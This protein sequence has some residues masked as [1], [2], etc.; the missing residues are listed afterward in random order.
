M[1]KAILKTMY[2]V[3]ILSSCLFETSALA[4][5]RDPEVYQIDAYAVNEKMAGAKGQVSISLYIVHNNAQVLINLKNRILTSDNV[6]KIEYLT[7]K[8]DYPLSKFEKTEDKVFFTI[9]S[10]VYEHILYVKHSLIGLGMGSKNTL[11]KDWESAPYFKKKKIS[12]LEGIINLSDG[13]FNGKCGKLT[14]KGKGAKEFPELTH[15]QKQEILYLQKYID[16]GKK[17]AQ[18][19]IDRIKDIY[20]GK[21]KFTNQSLKYP[22]EEMIKIIE[23]G[24]LDEIDTKMEKWGKS[25]KQKPL[26]TLFTLEEREA[27]LRMMQL[28]DE[29]NKIVE[30][31]LEA[32]NDSLRRTEFALKDDLE[33]I[34]ELKQSYGMEV[35][36]ED[37]ELLAKLELKDELEEINELKQN[38]GMEIST[39]DVELLAK[40]EPPPMPSTDPIAWTA[41]TQEDRIALEKQIKE[42]IKREHAKGQALADRKQFNDR[43][44][45]QPTQ[46]SSESIYKNAIPG[47]A[48]EDLPGGAGPR[49]LTQPNLW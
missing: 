49:T 27:Y 36:S 5:G 44:N 24:D 46:S 9:D 38:Y 11:R 3:F 17:I 40:L 21:D 6:M 19:Y 43:Q 14:L 10:V 29:A 37:V 34:N 12:D 4:W 33:E 35:S 45:S 20:E 16:K 32:L 30:S 41:L 25:D 47:Q 8:N 48:E 31:E 22:Y 18:E 28:S 13:S 7:V 23:N 26:A 2:L 42:Y 15:K 1:K 39:D